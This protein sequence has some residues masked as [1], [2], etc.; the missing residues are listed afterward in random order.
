VVLETLGL[1]GALDVQLRIEV[2]ETTLELLK[3]RSLPEDGGASVFGEPLHEPAVRRGLERAL[4]QLARLESDRDRQ[5]ALIDR[6]NE[7]RPLTWV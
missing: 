7:V 1:Q 3:T 4:R 5:I 6:A 2:L